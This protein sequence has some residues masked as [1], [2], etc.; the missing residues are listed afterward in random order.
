LRLQIED[1][2]IDDGRLWIGITAATFGHFA[3]HAGLRGKPI[4]IVNAQSP[5]R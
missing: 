5:I 2:R 3:A 1:S 4:P